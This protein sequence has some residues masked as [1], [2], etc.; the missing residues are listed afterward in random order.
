M[1]TTKAAQRATEKY[2]KTHMTR[3]N[4]KVKNAFGDEIKK[5]AAAAGMSMNGYISA[6]VRAYID[7]ENRK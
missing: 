5:A 3:F 2:V 4:F 1:A 6:A 7:N